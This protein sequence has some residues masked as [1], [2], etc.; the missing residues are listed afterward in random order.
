MREAVANPAGRKVAPSERA[1]SRAVDWEDFR[2]VCDELERT[3]QRCRAA[4]QE[5]A[6]ALLRCRGLQA[7]LANFRLPGYKVVKGYQTNIRFKQ[8]QA[9]RKRR[10]WILK[11]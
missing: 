6:A 11:A 7:K 4:E 1:S 5:A 9:A 3:K 8:S 10:R 2:A